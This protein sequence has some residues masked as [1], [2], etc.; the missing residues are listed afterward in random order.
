MCEQS[1]REL[2]QQMESE[3]KALLRKRKGLFGLW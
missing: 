2:L 1:D 3:D